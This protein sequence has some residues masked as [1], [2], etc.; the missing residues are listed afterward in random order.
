MTK[1]PEEKIPD[2][3][4]PDLI[5]WLGFTNTPNWSKARTLGGIAGMIL[6]LFFLAAFVAAAS[7]LFGT[8]E[9]S[10]QAPPQAP[11]LAQAR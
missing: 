11:T 6:S 4:A 5:A 9:M 8:T 7:V 2:A 1:P 3:S 10:L